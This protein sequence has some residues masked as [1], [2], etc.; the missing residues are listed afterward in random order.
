VA[1]LRSKRKIT[2]YIGR[3]Q[4]TGERHSL[5][6]MTWARKNFA[7]FFN[8]GLN[9]YPLYTLFLPFRIVPY[10]DGHS[11]ARRQGLERH[12]GV[13]EGEELTDEDDEET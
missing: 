9:G 5:I 13:Q 2:R 8:I 4:K 11:W 7:L 3:P 1:K 12:L 6:L 10:T